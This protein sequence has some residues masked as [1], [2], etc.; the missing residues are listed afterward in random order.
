MR[1]DFGQDITV[2]HNQL[3]HGIIP[4]FYSVTGVR[5]FYTSTAF[6]MLFYEMTA[7]KVLNG[8]LSHSLSGVTLLLYEICN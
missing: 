5:L 2:G 4:H 8:F 7:Y 6:E 1:V 3:R